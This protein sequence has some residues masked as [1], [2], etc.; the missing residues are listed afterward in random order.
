MAFSINDLDDVVKEYITNTGIHDHTEQADALTAQIR[1]VNVE[2]VDGRDMYAYLPIKTSSGAGFAYSTGTATENMPAD[3]VPQYKRMTVDAN[4]K[5]TGTISFDDTVIKNMKGSSQLLNAV[6][7]RK[8][9]LLNYFSKNNERSMNAGVY[10]ELAWVTDASTGA[11]SDVV[12]DNNK[13]LEVGL[14]VLTSQTGTI[15]TQT[16][17]QDIGNGLTGSTAYRVFSKSGNTKFVI[18]TAANISAQTDEWTLSGATAKRLFLDGVVT[19]SANLTPA[20]LCKL[21]DNKGEEDNSTWE[22][23]SEVPTTIQGLSRTTYNSLNCQIQHNSGTPETFSETKLDT[24]FDDIDDYA[25]ISGTN[26]AGRGNFSHI[27]YTNKGVKRALFAAYSDRE[28][29][30]MEYVELKLGHKAPT[31]IYENKMIPIVIG[32]MA[33]KNSLFVLNLNRLARFMGTE[34]YW[35]D[36]TNGVFSRMLASGAKVHGWEAFY[37]M[38]GNLGAYDFQSMGVMRDIKEQ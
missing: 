2:D 5:A 1:K 9:D 35:E 19:D 8:S 3:A 33:K 7:M 28:F 20:S 29:S 10:G 21:L 13:L 23:E 26:E 22:Y 11:E 17:D 38:Y 18:G 16:A 31:Y 34:G 30:N 36:G 37:S 4:K 32:K 6:D 24:L 25:P 14:R 15:L 27:I 12:V